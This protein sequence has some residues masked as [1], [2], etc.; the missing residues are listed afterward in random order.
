VALAMITGIAAAQAM[1]SG[2]AP[3]AT[4]KIVRWSPFDASGAPKKAL[5]LTSLGRGSCLDGPGSERIGDIGYRCGARGALADPCWRDGARPTDVVVCAPDPWGS[6]ASTIRVGH[7]ML[8]SGVTFAA[9]FDV[10]RRR[11]LPLGVELDNGDHCLLVQGAHESVP[12]PHGH[13]L[14]VDYTCDPSGIVLLHNLRRGGLWRIGAARYTRDGFEL[15]GDVTIARAIFGSLPPAMERQNT[16]AR[17]AVAATPFRRSDVLRVRLAFPAH[18]W[19]YVQALSG[20]RVVHRVGG[21]W[22]VVRVGRP[23]CASERL[24]AAVRRQLFGC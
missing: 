10:R 1:G 4:T 15:L 6:S 24:P 3:S 22:R 8:R 2:A 14:V 13:S 23:G 20:S 19:A 18:D 7:F 5:K 11:D 21:V 12:L 16:L 17:R 9:P